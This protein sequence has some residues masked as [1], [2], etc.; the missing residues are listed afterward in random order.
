MV[1]SVARGGIRG[2]TCGGSLQLSGERYRP[3]MR[4]N[5]PAALKDP[6]MR[7]I[8]RA[9]RTVFDLSGGRVA[10]G[11]FGMPVVKL[12]TTGR[13]SGLQRETMLTAPLETDDGGVVLVASNGGD[14]RHPAWYLNLAANPEVEI[15]TRGHRYRSEAHVATPDEK[16]ELWPRIEAAFPTYKAY[17]RMTDRDIPVVICNPEP[18]S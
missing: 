18:S 6:A 5:V 15:V 1:S 12:T 14:D 11:F 2:W 10:G 4:I 8:G 13:K 9:H 16:A 7:L 17:G 3:V